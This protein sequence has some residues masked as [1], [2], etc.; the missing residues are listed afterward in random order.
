MKRQVPT[1]WLLRGLAVAALTLVLALWAM[2]LPISAPSPP[3]TLVPTATAS[4]APTST[5]THTATASPTHTPKPTATCTVTPSP[6]STPTPT[7]TPAPSNTP[8]PT[9]TLVPPTAAVTA[10]SELTLAELAGQ[11]QQRTYLSQT[12]GGQE[13]YLVYLPPEYEY[14]DGRYPV[15][16]LLHG[17]PYDESHWTTLGVD[18]A[19]DAGI[20]GGTLPACIIVMPTGTERLYILTSGGNHSF[21]G[22]IIN[23]LVPHVDKTFR[24][25]ANREGRVI[26]GI[27]RGGV[28]A[29]E[30][31]FLHPD[32]FSAVGA[33]S[34]S[35]SLNLA[36]PLY[37][38]FHLLV[39]PGVAMLRIYLDAGDGDWAR[40]STQALHESLVA[41][42]IANSFVVHT[43]RHVTGLWQ[44]SLAEYLTFYTSGWPRG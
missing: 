44:D 38:P 24:T 14:A 34:P 1:S 29:L 23:D 36:P 25:W 33:H 12:T 7:P 37:D 4:P 32:I 13:S 2:V 42:N 5:R 19:A 3:P 11:T 30:I 8:T 21:E 43:G 10:T 17:W 40:Q 18:R 35:L 20:A 6:T 26:G 41:H 9:S 28:W 27:S 15:I 31:S 16:Y 22:Q 39:N